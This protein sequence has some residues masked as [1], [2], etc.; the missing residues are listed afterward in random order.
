M[1]MLKIHK[2]PQRILEVFQI[3]LQ[4]ILNIMPKTF[5]CRPAARSFAMRPNALWM[6]VVDKH[7]YFPTIFPAI[8][9]I[10]CFGWVMF[11][12]KEK[13][14]SPKLK[15]KKFFKFWTK[16]TLFFPVGMIVLKA[17]IQ[18]KILCWSEPLLY[19]IIR[20]RKKGQRQ[21]TRAR[22]RNATVI[23][24]ISWMHF[25][26]TKNWFKWSLNS[27]NQSTSLSKTTTIKF[28]GRINSFSHNDF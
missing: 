8:E 25:N 1:Q 9:R 5:P 27:W 24:M 13:R 19:E 6:V 14:F 26:F 3:Q 16:T 15:K 20:P 28:N 10:S 21:T 12:F 17:P 23:I 22:A 18:L 2:K 4:K 7:P 11:W